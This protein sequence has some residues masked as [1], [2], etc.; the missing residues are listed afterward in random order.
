MRRNNLFKGIAGVLTAGTIAVLAA[1]PAQ[2]AT[3]SSS[4]QYASWTDGTYTVYNDEW[5]SNYT[6]QG[7]WVNSASN[8]GVWSQQDYTSG[9]EAYPNVS[10]TVD[11]SI[12]SLSSVTSTY[13]V[14]DPSAGSY[15]TAYDIWT[16]DGANEIMIWTDVHNVGPLGSS[17]GTVT[18]DGQTYTVYKGTNGSNNVYSFVD[19]ST[20]TSGTFNILDILKWIQNTKGWMSNETLGQVQ[21]GWEITTENPGQDFTVNSYSVS[22]S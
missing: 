14:T 15:E 4:D 22:F 5:G 11:K 21:F 1:G 6:Y 10:R 17:V 20:V 12:S 18:L 8:W 7:L 16:E 9:V 3:Y 2:A 19:S 13:S